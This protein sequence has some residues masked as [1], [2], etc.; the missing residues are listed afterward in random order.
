MLLFSFILLIMNNVLLYNVC[1][2]P[3]TLN[4]IFYKKMN[5]ESQS[6]IN[7]KYFKWFPII[8]IFLFLFHSYNLNFLLMYLE[9]IQK[10]I[11]NHP[12][13]LEVAWDCYPSLLSLIH[14]SL[15]VISVNLIHHFNFQFIYSV[16]LLFLLIYKSFSISILIHFRVSFLIIYSQQTIIKFLY[17]YQL[18]W[19]LNF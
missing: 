6:P 10:I 8:T 14:N 17:L 12:Y 18:L 16:N 19:I 3:L 7:V 1:I 11:S 9:F 5:L 13:Q 4:P 2:L 15:I